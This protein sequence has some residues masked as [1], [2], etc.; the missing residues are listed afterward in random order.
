MHIVVDGRGEGG[1]SQSSN[2]ARLDAG[3]QANQSAGDASGVGAVF[4]V[5]DSPMLQV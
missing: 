3:P 2:D 1:E 5:R 4:P